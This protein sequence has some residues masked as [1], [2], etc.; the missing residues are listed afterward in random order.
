M[1]PVFLQAVIDIVIFLS[2]YAIVTT[3][4]NYQY[5][6]T[7]IPN[8]GLAFAVAGGAYITGFL[9]GR[10]AYMLLLPNSTLDYVK[11]NPKIM[12]Q[13]NSILE[14]DPT[15]SITLLLL[16][17]IAAILVGALLGFIATFPAIR[18]RADFLMMTLIALAE[19]VRIIGMNYE[20]LAGGTL[21]IRV[22]RMLDWTGLDATLQN[23]FLI[24]G[25]CILVLVFNWFM[26]HSPYGR[27]LRAIRENEDAAIA[28]GKNV[29]RIRMEVMIVGSAIAAIAGALSGIYIGNVIPP[30]YN[31]IDWTFWPWL[32]LMLGGPGSEMG[33]L[34]GTSAI[35]VI[36][37]LVSIYK[38]GVQP[39]IPF[40]VVWLERMALGIA[41]LVIMV[42][43]PAGLIPEKPLKMKG[44][45]DRELKKDGGTEE[46]LG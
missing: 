2:L 21:G 5:G 1:I 46:K 14:K 29:N 35:V 41:F 13:I 7:G 11:D 3:A 33:A 42:F 37:R 25:G 16:T 43:K 27:L 9:P 4:L 18:L 22:P 24:G 31:R 28:V 44:L 32:M 23:L 34:A 6:Y 10:L 38:H 39:F 17:F 19:A 8:F 15:L 36:R 26:L 12:V 20:P 40:D 30:A 45:H